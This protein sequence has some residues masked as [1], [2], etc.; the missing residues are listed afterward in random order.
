MKFTEK[1][2][3]REFIMGCYSEKSNCDGA[4]ALKALGK[5]IG[6]IHS[7]NYRQIWGINFCNKPTVEEWKGFRCITI[8]C[9]I[10]WSF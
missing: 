8:V 5:I 1:I 10:E 2:P 3:L 4:A 9:G 7:Q 6:L